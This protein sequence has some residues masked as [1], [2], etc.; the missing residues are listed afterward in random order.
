[1]VVHRA[2]DITFLFHIEISDILQYFFTGFRIKSP[3]NARFQ[4]LSIGEYH[5]LDAS[6]ICRIK[7]IPGT[8]CDLLILSLNRPE[9]LNTTTLLAASIILSPVTGFRP[10]LSRFFF[11]QN[12]PNPLI[13]IS[14]PEANFDLISS[15]RVSTSSTA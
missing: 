9:H 13:R 7:H 12:F 2:A 8:Y 3:P 1:M 5:R 11:T 10:R 6:V 14:S 15:S 4:N